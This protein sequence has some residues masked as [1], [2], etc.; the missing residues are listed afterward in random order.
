MSAKRYAA[1]DLGASSGR[2]LVGTVGDASVEVAQVHRFP[3]EPVRLPD[4]L[5]W[6]VLGLYR[7][8]RQGLAAAGPVASAGIDS[9]A[10]DYGL[11][12]EIGSLLG[13]PFH[14][15]DERTAD[16][17]DWPDPAGLWRAT[18]IAHQPFNTLHQL[19]AESTW[20]LAE[21]A[22]LLM[23]PD[24][25]GYWLTGA[26]GAERTNASTTQLY[27]VE[28]GWSEAVAAAAGIDVSILPPVRR[29]GD[30]IGETDMGVPLVAVASHDTASA[31]AAVPA[32][33]EKFAYISCG[34]W[35]LAGLELDGPVLSEGARLAGFTNEAGVD[36]T[37]RFLRNVMGLWLLQEC[38][39]FWGEDS[40]EALLSAAAQA[41]PFAA[42]ID[43]QDPAWLA[44]G[45]EPGGMPA[46]IAAKADGV[47]DSR[48]AIVR[49]VLES[50]ALGHR[51]AVA[52]AAALAGREVEAVHLVGGGSRNALLCQW[53][54]DAT[55]LPVL[56]GP[57]EATALGNL[58]V[59]A[60]ADGVVADLAHLRALVRQT[61]RVVRYEPRP[62]PGWHEALE[63]VA[64][65]RRP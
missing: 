58:L 64:K 3:N 10:V 54:A 62:S 25:L 19:R 29:P 13:L 60:R 46:R 38:Q 35:S 31:I 39:R 5:H 30:L 52:E 45:D 17:P 36:G 2:V 1:V 59:Q 18:G 47:L 61:Q 27:R 9:W 34:T 37:V 7:H 20:R 49:C 15:R 6:D 21:A 24:L 55:G 8:L 65:A 56:A 53:T 26:I 50:L 41:K 33:S 48:G 40:V 32:E 44:R 51:N 11:V 4:G 23:I 14:Y 28:G 43:P 63:R 16:L 57:V 12:D 22:H 42:L